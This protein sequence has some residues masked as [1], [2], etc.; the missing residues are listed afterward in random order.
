MVLML[1]ALVWTS[2]RWHILGSIGAAVGWSY[3]PKLDCQVLRL[4]ADG[5]RHLVRFVT[6]AQAGTI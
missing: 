1:S 6:S 5:K 3:N 4:H 2:G